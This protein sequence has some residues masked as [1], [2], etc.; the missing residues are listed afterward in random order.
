LDVI[1][2]SAHTARLI[3]VNPTDTEW[4]YKFDMYLRDT[5][6]QRHTVSSITE[7]TVQPGETKEVVLECTMP[8]AAGVHDVLIDVYVDEDLILGMVGTEQISVVGEPPQPGDF[9]YSWKNV[10][11]RQSGPD[12]GYFDAT[13][14]I[15][16]VSPFAQTRTIIKKLTVGNSSDQKVIGDYTLQPSESIQMTVTSGDMREQPVSDIK[17][18]FWIEDNYGS[19]SSKQYHYH[20]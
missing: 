16:N 20:P 9:T 3:V 18:Y 7:A 6:G 14:T 4:T 5:A 1:P 12:Y 8:T 2:G 13:I 19:K 11:W 10:Y 15:R 17:I